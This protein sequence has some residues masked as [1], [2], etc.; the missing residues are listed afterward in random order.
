MY[1]SVNRVTTICIEWVG[2]EMRHVLVK[3]G[4]KRGDQRPCLSGAAGQLRI[5][6]MHVVH[7]VSCNIKWN[8]AICH[9]VAGIRSTSGFV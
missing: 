7:V 6:D 3:G 1:D 8:N 4:S 5:S 9:I 2:W